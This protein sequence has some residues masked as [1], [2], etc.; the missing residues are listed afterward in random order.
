M[1]S[2]LLSVSILLSAL[3]FGVSA[4]YAMPPLAR[5]TVGTIETV[6]LAHRKLVIR[7]E[8][9]TESLRLAFDQ[10]TT[11]WSGSQSATAAAL[12]RGQI[13]QVSFR[14]PF[15]GPDY[16]SRIVLLSPNKTS[17]P[18]PQNKP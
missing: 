2:R 6:D 11:I 9:R 10:R 7:S 3:T 15:F 16:A 5:R 14:L 1:N 12:T 13:V 4:T 18:K 17:K 8:A